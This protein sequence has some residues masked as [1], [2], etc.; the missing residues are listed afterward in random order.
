MGGYG[1]SDGGVGYDAAPGAGYGDHGGYGGG[2]AMGGGY[3]G[4]DGGYGGYG[5]DELNLLVESFDEVVELFGI[6]YIYNPVDKV[7]LELESADAAEEEDS[8]GV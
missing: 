6:I 7:K 2:S 3:G 4:E 1:S 5:E 8:T